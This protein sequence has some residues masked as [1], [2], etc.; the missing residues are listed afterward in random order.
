MKKILFILFTTIIVQAQTCKTYDATYAMA[1]EKLKERSPK[2]SREMYDLSNA[3]ID[4][5]LEYLAY[6]KADISFADQYQMRQAIKR[7]DQKRHDYFIGA[8][9]EYHVKYGI[10][11]KVTEI[12]QQ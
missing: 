10:K 2:S 6:C 4:R 12:Y 7:A 5:G 9:R 8:V 1:Q 3:L 11:P